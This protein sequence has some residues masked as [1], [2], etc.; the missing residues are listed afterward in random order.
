M[1]CSISSSGLPEWVELKLLARDPVGLSDP[2]PSPVEALIE[3]ARQHQRRRR[4]RWGAS[5]A[6]ALVVGV[7]LMV[8][9]SGPGGPSGRPSHP[10]STPGNGA[11][12]QQTASAPTG[13][14]GT[15]VSAVGE[16]GP[17]AVW[18]MNGRTVFSSSNSGQSWRIITPPA[19]ADQSVAGRINSV[20]GFGSDDLWL[21]AM[22]V[23]GA[24]PNAQLEH[25]LNGSVRGTEMFYSTDAGVRWES[26]FLP[27]CVQSCGENPEVTFINAEDG[28][29]ALSAASSSGM[30]YLFST[31]DGGATWTL[32][33][34]PQM[35]GLSVV[36]T[37][38]QDGWAV[39]A[40]S[41]VGGESSGSLY[42]TTKGGVTWSRAPGLPA[43]RQYYLPVLV[44]EDALVF[45]P[46]PSPVVFVSNDQGSTWSGVP[47]PVRGS[48]SLSEPELWFSAPT[49]TAWFL[50]WRSSLVETTDAGRHW[51]NINEKA[52]FPDDP[53]PGR[54][55][56][57][58][59]GLDF[60]SPTAGLAIA[61]VRP[62]KAPGGCASE[63]LIATSN[64]GR[65]WRY[66]NP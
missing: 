25:S 26:S 11:V 57:V 60:T 59:W 10:A 16:L 40:E 61:G 51:T 21:G 50:S 13:V 52:A 65:T 14:P 1:S 44:G 6:V 29:A 32:V 2:A 41:A 42:E 31:T 38:T 37:N 33:S 19:L 55:K 53:G 35:A 47:V 63:A 62:C 22:D 5:L 66:L 48:A 9:L 27:G 30:S 28:F 3:E 23:I 64:A 43:Q 20:I 8:G 54:P 18:A 56:P 46:T 12:S 24:V 58:V 39:N 4:R 36:F 15:L 49:P 34:T 45:S 17:G 7:V